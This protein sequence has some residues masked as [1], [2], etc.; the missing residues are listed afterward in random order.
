MA[1]LAMAGIPYERWIKFVWKL[2]LGWLAISAAAI[3]IAVL[4]GIQ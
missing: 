2:I 4:I 3:I 1:T